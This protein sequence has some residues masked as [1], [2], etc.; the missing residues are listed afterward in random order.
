MDRT[1][2]ESTPALGTSEYVVSVTCGF[3]LGLT[4]MFG[5][6]KITEGGEEEEEEEAT[7]DAS[8][9]RSRSRPLLEGEAGKQAMQTF[10]NTVMPKLDTDIELLEKGIADK[11][12]EEIDRVLHST[13]HHVDQGVRS[14]KPKQP[15]DAGNLA[16]MQFHLGELKEQGQQV[17]AAASKASVEDARN[18]LRAFEGTLEHIHEHTEL[19]RFC[20]WKPKPMPHSDELDKLSEKIPW[21]VVAA[22]AV[23]GAVDG[24]LIGLAF[25]ADHTAGWAMSIATCI[26]MGFLGLSFCAELTNATRKKVKVVLIAM[27]P[28]LALLAAGVIGSHLGGSLD[29]NPQIFTGFI[30]FSIVALLFLVT[31]EL[32]TEAREVAEDDMIING[33]IFVGI[34]GGVLLSKFLG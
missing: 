33:M 29:A 15:L 23:D 10:S 4:F 11:S 22:V 25:A 21:S 17:K 32:L 20:R 14:L 9:E 5:I 8:P 13:M 19:G 34:L 26:E 6:K 28:P 7:G 24:L 3:A 12:R 18:A 16:R 30:A 31:Q 27:V 2:S 1:T